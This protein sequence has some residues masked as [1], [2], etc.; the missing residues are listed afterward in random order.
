MKPIEIKYI[1]SWILN[2][3]GSINQ[4]TI[5]EMDIGLIDNNGHSFEV[6]FQTFKNIKKFWNVNSVSKC[7]VS[8]CWSY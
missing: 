6:S 2:K 8:K 1:F 5:I 4:K 7:C 3:L